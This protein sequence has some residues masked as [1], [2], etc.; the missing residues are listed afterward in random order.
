MINEGRHGPQK[1]ATEVEFRGICETDGEY[2]KCVL[3]CLGAE[4]NDARSIWCLQ[5]SSA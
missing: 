5:A 4:M 3:S 1:V 2:F